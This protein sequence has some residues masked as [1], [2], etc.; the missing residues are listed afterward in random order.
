VGV[1]GGMGPLAS[2]EFIKTIYE[3]SL[4]R[5]EQ[6][7]PNVVLHSD[8]SMP[9]RTTAF[10][11]GEPEEVLA[12]F[13]A[14]LESLT[15]EGVAK[16]V[17]CC[18]TIHYLLPQ[19]PLQLRCRIVSLLDVISQAVTATPERHLLLCTT[20]TRRLRLFETHPSWTAMRDHLV[21]LDE[22]DQEVVHD[23]IYRVKQHGDVPLLVRTVERLL[24]K[25]GVRSFVAACTEVHFAAKQFGGGA[26][27]SFGC[28][29][30]LQ[31][32]ARDIA[33]GRI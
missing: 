1:L 22:Q 16:I 13:I 11:T 15:R 14:G 26:T 17:V 19:L 3:A 29:D 12:R 4:D 8:P 24:Q 31:I 32:I 30:P 7:A 23:T 20:G 27:G 25:Y 18:V 2:A 9:D 33:Q 10:L 28:V 5:P 21:M 6:R